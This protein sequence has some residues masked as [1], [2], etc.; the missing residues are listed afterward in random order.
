MTL[1][2]LMPSLFDAPANDMFW[3][4]NIL[5]ASSYCASLSSRVHS[6][7][8]VFLLAGHGEESVAW[9]SVSQTVRGKTSG[10]V[11]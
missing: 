6:P 3:G 4:C 5:T 7:A 8:Y 2:D 10:L 1:M 9:M 11:G